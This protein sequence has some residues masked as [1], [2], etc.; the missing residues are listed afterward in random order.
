M[1]KYYQPELTL[2]MSRVLP[3]DYFLLC[4]R[5]CR[6]DRKINKESQKTESW[7][8]RQQRQGLLTT[9][10]NIYMADEINPLAFS[11]KGLQN[12]ESGGLRKPRKGLQATKRNKYTFWK[13]FIKQSMLDPRPILVDGP[14]RNESQMTWAQDLAG[15][16]NAVLLGLCVRIYLQPPV[17]SQSSCEV[18][19]LY[20][21]L[22][23]M[24]YVVSNMY[25][26]ASSMYYRIY[27]MYYVISNMYCSFYY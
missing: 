17:C 23:N 11:N 26:E 10:R 24:H 1:L 14:G 25:Y 4:V 18:T 8:L 12:T 5:K 13:P 7:V 15:S 27:D 6:P 20:Y 9:K 16:H 21:V 3:R 2:Y 19:D 22:S